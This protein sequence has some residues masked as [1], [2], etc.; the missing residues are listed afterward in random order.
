MRVRGP[1]E[2]VAKTRR[3]RCAESGVVL[4][5]DGRVD[6]GNV[7]TSPS[8]QYI[9]APDENGRADIRR[10]SSESTRFGAGTTA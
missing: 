10:P 8:W 2:Q 7:E 5:D 9:G 3:A 4:R 6:A 1:R